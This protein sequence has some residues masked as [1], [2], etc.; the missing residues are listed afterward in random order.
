METAH[1]CI[2]HVTLPGVHQPPGAKTCQYLAMKLKVNTRFT[3]SS[4]AQESITQVGSKKQKQAL[5]LGPTKGDKV[6]K[7][8]QRGP[9]G[10]GYLIAMAIAVII[11]YTKNLC[12][13]V[14]GCPL[15][16]HLPVLGLS[17][18]SHRPDQQGIRKG[19]IML[20]AL[21]IF[22][23]IS[24]DKNKQGRLSYVSPTKSK[25]PVSQCLHSQEWTEDRPHVGRR[26]SQMFSL[27]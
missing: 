8:T 25:P 6:K 21:S 17:L 20:L 26:R 10:T 12:L 27:W 16:R 5:Q 18:V 3:A 13:P 14:W 2:T 15:M 22:L 4:K 9:H 23:N 19:R 24:R 11:C 1:T 7:E